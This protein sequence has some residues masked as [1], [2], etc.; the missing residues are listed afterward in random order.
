MEVKVNKSDIGP[1]FDDSYILTEWSVFNDI[2]HFVRFLTLSGK[3]NITELWHLLLNL[4]SPR[5]C[6]SSCRRT[7]VAPVYV[8][9]TCVMKEIFM[10]PPMVCMFRPLLPSKKPL[11]S[12]SLWD[13]SRLVGYFCFYSTLFAR[14]LYYNLTPNM[15]YFQNV[16]CSVTTAEF[17]YDS[18]CIIF[19]QV[20][21]CHDCLSNV[22]L[23]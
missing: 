11:Q 10:W 21:L 2:C 12:T 22:S 8:C 7:A 4:R 9:I 23:M 3:K 20:M 19:L 17:Q 1:V 13:S 6:G 5:D 18:I 15:L 16:Q 14:I